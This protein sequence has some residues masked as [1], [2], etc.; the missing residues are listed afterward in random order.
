MIT[1]VNGDSGDGFRLHL[2]KILRAPP[3][4][5]FAAC[6]QPETL[7]DWWGPAGFTAPCVDLDVRERGR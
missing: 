6:V 5:V 7:A 2:E 3:E 1:R 4:R